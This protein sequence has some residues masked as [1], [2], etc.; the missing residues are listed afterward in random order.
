MSFRSSHWHSLLP[1][2]TQWCCMKIV[3]LD[4]CTSVKSCTS[5]E[6]CT[7]VKSC[8]SVESVLKYQN[9][10]NILCYN[11]QHINTGPLQVPWLNN[12]WHEQLL[13][14][15]LQK[16]TSKSTPYMQCIVFPSIAIQRRWLQAAKWC[17]ILIRSRL[18]R[19][20]AAAAGVGVEW[21]TSI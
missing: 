5:V 20:P 4:F 11:T 21:K 8:T 1:T 17:N 18:S 12:I 9:M 3:Q 15:V 7:S 6:S 13:W 10:H 16:I 14:P 19:S 2:L